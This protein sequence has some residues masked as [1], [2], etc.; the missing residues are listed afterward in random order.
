MIHRRQ[1]LLG[2]RPA[3]PHPNWLAQPAGGAVLSHCPELA[4]RPAVDR[5]GVEW[6]ILGIASQTDP[7]RPDPADQIAVA[8]TEAVPRLTWTWAGR[9][10]LIGN[11]RIYLDAAGLLGCYYRRGLGGEGCWAS[12]S[13]ALLAALDGAAGIAAPRAEAQAG[14]AAPDPRPLRHGVGLDWYPPPRSGFR[15]IR[16]LL[17]SQALDL[18]SGAPVPGSGLP[19]LERTRPWAEA[20][21]LLEEHLV[22]GLARLPRPSGRIWI[23]LTSGHDSRLVLAAAL[24]AGLP[25]E[26]YTH[27]RSDLPAGDRLLPPRLAR[28]VG[29]RHRF[30]RPGRH[31]APAEADYDAHCGGQSAG[32]DRGYYARGQWGFAGPGD[33][34][35][36][37]NSADLGRVPWHNT[38]PPP[39]GPEMLP[40]PEEIVRWIREP[41]GSS[42]LLGLREWL[43]HARAH[44]VS[45]LE[46]RD[47]FHWEQRLGGWLGALEQSLDLLPCARTHP[48]NSAQIYGLLLALPAARRAAG[49]HHREIIGRLAPELLEFPFNPPD[50]AFGRW[51]VARDRLRNDPA[52]FWRAVRKRLRVG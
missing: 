27:L 48:A 26:T 7:D 44:P 35:L 22:T 51:A 30:T 11:G 4:V 3:A 16:R 45:G 39:P 24:R 40:E 37:T 28:A 19:P 33:L 34:L 21:R 8:S 43:D 17:P 6:Y 5:C 23:P 14:A 2:P 13:A 41:E 20:I 25:V 10:L 49:E 15:G 52:A 12:S 42:A 31:S 1:F 32:V 36:R 9:W 47:R 18:A 50:D 29:L 46:W 38:F